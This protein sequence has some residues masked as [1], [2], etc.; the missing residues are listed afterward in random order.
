MSIEFDFGKLSSIE[1]YQQIIGDRLKEVDVALLFLN[2]GTST[3]GPF[4]QVPAKRIDE[5]VKVNAV[6][7]IF[8]AKVL[9]DQMVKREKRSGIVVTSSGLAQRPIAGGLVYS[10]SKTFASFTAVALSYEVQDK[11]DV[12]SW[13]S[14]GVNTKMMPAERGKK[15]IST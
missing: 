13:E 14:A 15:Q 5:I 10:A 1:E 4:V 2:A 7:P 8:T 6:H 9:I 3:M 11:V 12:M